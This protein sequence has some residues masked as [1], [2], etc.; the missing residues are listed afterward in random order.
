MKKRKVV[1]KYKYCR[2]QDEEEPDFDVKRSTAKARA[3]G[4][5]VW[6]G[7]ARRRAFLLDCL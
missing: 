2:G 1:E 7:M 3:Q 6:T 4:Y 5:W